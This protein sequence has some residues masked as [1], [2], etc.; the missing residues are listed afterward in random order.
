MYSNTIVNGLYS[1]CPVFVVCITF[2]RPRGR[3]R[4]W[5]SWRFYCIVY[6]EVIMACIQNNL[7]HLILR[8]V[9]HNVCWL[10]HLWLCTHFDVTS[11]SLC[12]SFL[13]VSSLSFLPL[14]SSEKVNSF[15]T[16][17]VRRGHG[18]AA[19]G[20]AAKVIGTFDNIRDSK[21]SGCN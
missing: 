12:L 4:D 15:F 10:T 8:K 19:K 17:Q 11:P 9:I 13:S 16:L 20:W 14:R 3:E 5:G 7:I 21:V 1:T 18:D 2:K 6:C